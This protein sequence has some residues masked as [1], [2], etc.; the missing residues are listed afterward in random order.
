MKRATFEAKTLE[1]AKEIA[2]E[3]LRVNR[4]FIKLDARERK[5]FLSLR[6]G[7]E[8]EASIDV[9]PA[10]LGRKTLATLFEDMRVKAEIRVDEPADR[11]IVYDCDTNA[12]PVLIGKNGKTLEGIQVY[13]RNLLNVYTDEH[14]LVVVDIGGYRKN[15]KKKLEILATQTAKEVARTKTEVKL[16]PMNAYERRIVHT[17]LADW[18]DVYTKSEGEKD[19][20]HL[21]IKPKKK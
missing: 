18:N 4:R 20:R 10:E 13:L 16:S 2:E 21:V 1:D 7:Y 11:E 3:K 12:N 15:R 14:L 17:K 8:V 6:K 19:K 9:D 5:G